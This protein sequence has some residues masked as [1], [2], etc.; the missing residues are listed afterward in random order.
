MKRPADL[1]VTLHTRE[2]PHDQEG[3]LSPLQR[4]PPLTSR[5]LALL[6]RAHPTPV[7]TIQLP[8]LAAHCP[9]PTW[10]HHRPGACRQPAESLQPLEHK[11]PTQMRGSGATQTFAKEAHTGT[12]SPSPMLLEKTSFSHWSTQMQRAW[13]WSR[14]LTTNKFK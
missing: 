14:Q 7:P 3:K 13:T 12:L 9:C 1:G 5:P 10:L 11:G 8:A 4:S 6:S 2:A